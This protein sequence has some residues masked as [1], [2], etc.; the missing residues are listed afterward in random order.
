VPK[1]DQRPDP[2]LSA[3]LKRLREDRKLSQ[4]TLAQR[5]QI[6]SST[7]ARIEAGRIVPSWATVTA[8][9]DAL[10]V[11]LVELARAVEQAS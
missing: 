7:L 10:G 5:A 8:L 3:A 11:S 2:A 1:K 6:T 4:E 9:A